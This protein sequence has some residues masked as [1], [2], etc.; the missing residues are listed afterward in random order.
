MDCAKCKRKK[1]TIKLPS[2]EHVCEDCFSKII[3]KRVRKR[4]RLGK[5]FRK[6][7]RILVTDTLSK[8]LILKIIKDLPVKIFTSKSISKPFIK[9]NKISKVVAKRTM[10]DEL[11]SFFE[12]LFY[13]KHKKRE[14][15]L[16]VLKGMTDNEAIVFSRINK[17]AFKPNSRNKEILKLM[18]NLE[19]K[20][21]EIRFSLF[22]SIS[23][24]EK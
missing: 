3:E 17:L 24:L 13:G 21:P 4:I 7:D 9:S 12:T 15:Y 18:N 11:E 14:N 10:D 1:K 19:K 5:F 20:Y 8:Y 23:E 16:S 22:R 2:M 6:G